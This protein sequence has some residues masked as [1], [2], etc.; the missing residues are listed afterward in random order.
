VKAKEIIILVNTGKS[1]GRDLLRGI[2]RFSTSAQHWRLRIC[3]F[4]DNG[5][6]RFFDF[7]SHEHIDGIITSEL[8]NGGIA[9][10]LETS[11]IPL[12]VI[13]TRKSALPTRTENLVVVT[14]DE[15]SVGALGAQTLQKLGTF[16]AFAFVNMRNDTYRYLSLL[17]NQGFASQL[18]KAG[19][20]PQSYDTEIPESES[21]EMTLC[22]W[23]RALP[24]PAAVLAASD[25]RAVD[26]LRATIQTG[27]RVPEDVSI[28]GID[29]DEF[30]CLSTTPTLSSIHLDAEG[31]GFEAARQLDIMLR[32]RQP[33]KGRTRHFAG[34]LNVV[35]RWSTRTLAPGKALVSRI[36]EFISQNAD[37]PLTI[38]EIVAFS[39]VSQRLLFLRFKEFSDKS[40]QETIN[41]ERIKYFCKRLRT[42][43]GTIQDVA[44]RCGFNNMATLRSLFTSIT[45]MTIREWRRQ[46]KDS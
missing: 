4:A 19:V 9:K 8:E 37:R 39:H 35:H 28:L 7:Y 34:K 43:N 36:R 30:K 3:D 6:Q 27:F 46:A 23:I 5:A 24:K 10:A 45:G 14:L 42:G 2:L 44:T 22:E 40:I 29:D 41:A 13:G 16:N 20:T 18:Q 11:P 21:D 15:V 1:S 33:H 31:Q 26:V 17:R 32:R 25:A 38:R 12:V